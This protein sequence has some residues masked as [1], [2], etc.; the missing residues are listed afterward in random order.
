MPDRAERLA[1]NEAAFRLIN[2]RAAKEAPEPDESAVKPYL[3]ECSDL[4]C[5]QQV[6]L[7]TGEY[8]SVRRDS[9]WFL[10]AVG[11]V[12]STVER[13]V[14]HTLRFD[15]VQKHESVRS[16]VGQTDPRASWR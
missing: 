15:V 11:H 9:R 3:C 5:R 10:V 12:D 4:G 8:E 13:V 7:R 6:Y 1:R 2:E 14:D 16:V